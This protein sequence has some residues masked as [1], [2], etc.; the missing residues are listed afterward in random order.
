MVQRDE[1][2]FLW[3]DTAEPHA[4][5]RQSILKAHP[6]ISKLNGPDWRSKYIC[7]LG[8]VLPQL[9]LSTRVHSLSWPMY[10]VVAYAVGATLT[11]S[12][13]LAIHE[14]SHNLFFAT[15]RHNRLFSW[16][17]NFP[18]VVP[19]A[20]AFRVYHLEHHKAQGEDGVDTDVPTSLEARLVRGRLA[21]LIWLSFQ[22]VAYALRPILVRPTRIRTDMVGNWLAQMCFDVLFWKLYGPDP[23]KFLLLC[24]VLAGGLHPCA[25][26]FVAEH[27]VF[28]SDAQETYSY[29]GP[30]NMVA[31]NVGYHNE[32]HDF[33]YVAWSKLPRVKEAAPE[34]YALHTHSSWCRV[35][36]DYI[37]RDDMGPYSRVKRKRSE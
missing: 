14:L 19:F 36:Y 29:Y 26:H 27:Y 8:L 22:I 16:I 35:L 25:G 17:V 5:R 12:I 1:V 10:L 34:F 33:P 21:K 31:W 6:E 30:L 20:A 9:W 23:L 4:K 13:F 24:V 15:S 18:I 2:G 32:H 28:S 11:Q 7:I 3:S 37:L